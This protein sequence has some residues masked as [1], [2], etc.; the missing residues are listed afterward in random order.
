MTAPS[1]AEKK[2]AEQSLLYRRYRAAKKEQFE[3]LFGRDE[4]GA[5]LR[6]FNASLGHFGTDDAERMIA[7][8]RAECRKWLSS[9]PEDIRFVALQMVGHRITRIR[10]RAGLCE[11]DDPLPGEDDD[12]Y[13][14]CREAI[15][16]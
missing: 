4:D 3:E 2:V 14:L 7:Y 8:I 12:V 11:F 1:P 13:R 15:G 10:Q 16:L 5:N 6:K 9:A